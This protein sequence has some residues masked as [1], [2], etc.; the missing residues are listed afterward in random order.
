MPDEIVDT[1]ERF[2][3]LSPDMLGVAGFD[4]YWKRI[5]S[6]WTQILGFTQ[7]E[8]LARPYLDFVHPEDRSATVAEAEELASGS[9]TVR[10]T[11]R[12]QNRDGSYRWLEWRAMPSMSTETIY[13][14]ARDVTRE[15]ELE[16]DLRRASLA[17]DTRLALLSALVEAIGVGVIL[18]DREMLVAQWK[19]RKSTRLN[20]S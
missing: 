10:F 6:A 4:G 17:A 20:S 13:A 16:R 1:Y 7:E 18:V 12:Y 19:D 5:N 3:N 15:V 8:L 11:N 9:T 2:F 14:V